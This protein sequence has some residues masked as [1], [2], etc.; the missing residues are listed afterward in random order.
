MYVYNTD[1][2]PYVEFGD[3]IK[4][5][6]RMVFSP[7]IGNAQEVNIVVCNI[8]PNAISEGHRHEESD[9][10]I[11]FNIAGKAIIDGET[12][13]VPANSFLF[14]PKGCKHECINISI[15]EE[16]QL[17]CFFTP[18]FIPYGKYP[19]LIKKTKLYLSE[20]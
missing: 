14:A 19:D 3:Q 11:H 20:K 17:L 1:D 7:D 2:F 8:P 9:E 6:I 18:A 16:L 13:D 4:R 12:F 15:S 10:I 5:Q